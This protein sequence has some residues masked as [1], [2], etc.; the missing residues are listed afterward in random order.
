MT[1]NKA[2]A[3][4]VREI[5]NEKQ[6][7]QSKLEEISGIYHSTMNSALNGPTKASNFRTIAIIIK[8]LGVSLSEFFDSPVFDFKKIDVDA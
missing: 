1:L 5:L 8:S 4:R 3:I 7:T 6:M 2:I